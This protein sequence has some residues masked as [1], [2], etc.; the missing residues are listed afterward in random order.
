[1]GAAR[2]VSQVASAPDIRIKAQDVSGAKTKILRINESPH[3][4]TMPPVAT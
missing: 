1:M 3:A 4:N 2:A